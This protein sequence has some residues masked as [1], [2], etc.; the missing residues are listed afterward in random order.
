MDRLVGQLSCGTNAA[1]KNTGDVHNKRRELVVWSEVM[2]DSIFK[3]IEDGNIAYG[4]TTALRLGEEAQGR[5]YENVAKYKERIL[6]RDQATINNAAMISQLGLIAFNTPLEIDIFGHGN[7]SSVGGVKIMNG[8]GGSA[9][10][11][12]HARI[13]IM[14]A[15]STRPTRSDPHGAYVCQIIICTHCIVATPGCDFL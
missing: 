13:S 3:H 2:A 8:I 14:H 9:E 7:S 1:D 4:C 5:L 15:F 10:F 12:R 6:L 11:T